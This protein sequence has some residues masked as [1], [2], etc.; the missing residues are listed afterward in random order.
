MVI[1][2]GDMTVFDFDDCCYFW[3]MYELASAWEGGIGR[4]EVHGA[5]LRVWGLGYG[6]EAGAMRG[7]PDY[8]DANG[9]PAREGVWGAFHH[10][11]DKVDGRCVIESRGHIAL[12]SRLVVAACIRRRR[13][14]NASRVWFCQSP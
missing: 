10:P 8:L 14:G 6:G 11:R 3:F 9:L 5:G 4:V 2:T 1:A 7:I 12:L 13:A